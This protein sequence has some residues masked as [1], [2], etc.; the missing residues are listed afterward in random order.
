MV[1]AS[2]IALTCML[3]HIACVQQLEISACLGTPQG[4]TA[5]LPQLLHTEAAVHSCKHCQKPLNGKQG[6]RA[7]FC[8]KQCHGGWLV[9]NSTGQNNPCW[10]GVS[11]KLT[12][13]Q[14]GGSFSV[15]RALFNKQGGKFCSLKCFGKFKSA[16]SKTHNHPFRYAGQLLPCK[17]CG[18]EFYIQNC[19]LRK[20][21]KKYCSTKCNPH[22]IKPGQFAREKHPAWKGGVTSLSE[23]IR[24]SIT[25][26]QWRRAVMQRDKFT[27]QECGQVGGN[28]SAHHIK[29]F[30]TNPELRL[31]VPNGITLCRSCHKQLRGFEDDHVSRLALKISTLL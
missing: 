7:K 28:L 27:C 24:A 11:A 16:L 8:N 13:A 31:F 21:V 5:A 6:G 25:Y 30:S 22:T 4:Y 26:K 17:T 18:N 19:D 15:A 29:K 10:R 3:A 2:C 20:G 12:C 23:A 14:C 9:T 1:S